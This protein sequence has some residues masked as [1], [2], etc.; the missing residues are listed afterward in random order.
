[1]P[2]INLRNLCTRKNFCDQLRSVLQLPHTDK[3]LGVLDD[4]ECYKHF[5]YFPPST[6]QRNHRHATSLE[7]IISSLSKQGPSVRISQYERLH[8]ARS[9]ATAV[10]QY[11]ATPWLKGSL[12]SEEIYFFGIDEALPM[13]QPPA[14]TAPHLNVRVKGPDGSL[15][16][17]AI[18]PPPSCVRN[19]I[20]FGLGVVLL[21]L[22][23]AQTLR[24]LQQPRDIQDSENCLTEFFG[25]TRAV[26][27]ISREM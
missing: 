1:M 26:S 8:L 18:F 4:V 15:C 27:S 13:Q 25:A 22:G 7:Q 2:L 19:T 6:P 14:L 23:Y 12:R 16:R 5:I 9:L 21:E 20:L 3:C 11:H 17:T 24:E 10:L